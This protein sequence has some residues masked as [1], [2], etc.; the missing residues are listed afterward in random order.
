MVMRPTIPLQL[1]ALF[2]LTLSAGA[3]LAQGVDASGSA[4]VSGASVTTEADSGPRWTHDPLEVGFYVG[5]MLLSEQTNTPESEESY[6]TKLGDA[7]FDFGARLGLYPVKYIGVEGEGGWILTKSSGDGGAY[8]GT[9]R[10][11]LVAQYPA[12]R[13]VPFLLVGGGV[14][15]GTCPAG[16]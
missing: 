5:A 10:F 12:G 1:A 7:G 13:V 15:G 11:H 6:K 14:M 8:L 3:S 4:S 16:G 9:G 2:A